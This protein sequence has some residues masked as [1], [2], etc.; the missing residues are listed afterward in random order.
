M[1]SVLAVFLRHERS[2]EQRLKRR[3]YYL[4]EISGNSGFDDVQ[5]FD[6]VSSD[7]Q[8]YCKL[9][10]GLEQT[11]FCISN[12]SSIYGLWVALRSQNVGR[13]KELSIMCKLRHSV[14]SVA[15][16]CLAVPQRPRSVTI[17]HII[18]CSFSRPTV[19]DPSATHRP[20]VVRYVWN[21]RDGL[22]MHPC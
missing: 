4:I 2:I 16:A 10:R 11:I 1:W 17:L 22:L 5:L 15:V 13:E 12:I 3:S 7:A 19:C 14:A 8:M 6:H 20:C 9:T 18:E 21:V